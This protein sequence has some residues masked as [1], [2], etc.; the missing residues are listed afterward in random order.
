MINL[1]YCP[2]FQRLT[3]YVLYCVY[4]KSLPSGFPLYNTHIAFPGV[5]ST[6]KFYSGSDLLL[7][8]TII[9]IT[10]VYSIIYVLPSLRG[11]FHATVGKHPPNY[12]KNLT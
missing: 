2:E 11:Y 8:I 4:L 3:N 9:F 12:R 5:Y 7:F 1:S 6:I 10:L